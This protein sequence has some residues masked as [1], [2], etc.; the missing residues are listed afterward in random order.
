MAL[1]TINRIGVLSLAKM[2]AIVYAFLGLLFG[3]IVSLFALL[4]AAVG[5]ASGRDSGGVAGMLFGIGAVIILPVFYGCLGFIGGLIT[6][7]I[8]NLAAKVVG[9]LEIEMS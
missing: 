6:A 1:Q 3:G 9:G 4:G 2:L 5:G 7:P 8:Y